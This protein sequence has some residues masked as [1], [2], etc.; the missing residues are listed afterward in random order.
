MKKNM[1]K[2][3]TFFDEEVAHADLFTASQGNNFSQEHP[4]KEK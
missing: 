1:T 3:D 4:N 2:S